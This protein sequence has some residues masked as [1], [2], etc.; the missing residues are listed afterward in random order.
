MYSKSDDQQDILKSKSE[1]DISMYPIPHQPYPTLFETNEMNATGGYYGK[2]SDNFLK[3]QKS[4]K[5]SSEQ[6][7]TRIT[8][9]RNHRKTIVK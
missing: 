9:T 8:I 5:L 2:L 6:M 4:E 3:L 7:P 1:L